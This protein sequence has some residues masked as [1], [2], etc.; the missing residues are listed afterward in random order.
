M[1]ATDCGLLWET[2]IEMIGEDP[3]TI[4]KIKLGMTNDGSPVLVMDIEER[5]PTSFGQPTCEMMEIATT[6]EEVSR[7]IERAYIM[8]REY[9]NQ[10]R[11]A[12]NG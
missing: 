12:R 1:Q 11:E 9:R 8:L 10:P 2:E 4:G 3:E 7:F 6:G 5:H